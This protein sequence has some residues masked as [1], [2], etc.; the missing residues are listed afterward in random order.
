MVNFFSEIS[1]S[2]PMYE[3]ERQRLTFVRHDAPRRESLVSDHGRVVVVY[4]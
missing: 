3:P 1:E 4:F 2:C